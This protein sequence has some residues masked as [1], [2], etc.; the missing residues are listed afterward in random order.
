VEVE[1]IAS[2]GARFSGAS[3]SVQ[4]DS[5]RKLSF[6]IPAG[7]A[8]GPSVAKLD[9]GTEHGSYEVGLYINRLAL[10]LGACFIRCWSGRQL[11]WHLGRSRRDSAKEEPKHSGYRT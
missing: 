2:D 10:T 4:Q 7:I 11:L 9:L 1:L 6:V 5:H 8:A 3:L